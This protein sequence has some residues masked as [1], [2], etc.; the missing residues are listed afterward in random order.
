MKPVVF[1]ANRG[2]IA[3]RIARSL[4]SLGYGSA[5]VFAPDDAMAP[6]RWLLTSCA[7][8]AAPAGYTD[9]AAL[10]AHARRAGATFVHP[11]YGFLS[12]DAGFAEAVADA[13]LTWVGP[14]PAAMRALGDKGAARVR[15]SALGLPIVEGVS[16]LRDD[17]AIGRAAAALGYPLLLKAP[18]AGGGR[19]LVRIDSAAGLPAATARARRVAGA[20]TPLV[21]ER[22]L[23][24]VRHVEVQVV[25]DGQRAMA[26]GTR[27]CST[28]RRL[29]KVIEEAPATA[30]STQAA[31]SMGAQ[32]E[33]LFVD[34]GYAGVGTAEF[35]LDADGHWTFLEVNPR[36][37]V[38]HTVTEE[39]FGIDLVAWQL[40][41]AAGEPL[42]AQAPLA[43]G[44]SIEARLTAEDPAADYTPQTGTVLLAHWPQGPGIRVDA[45][46]AEGSVV[47][48]A[49]DALL[50]KIVAT[51][52]TR[53]QA[54]ARLL[55]ALEEVQ[56]LGVGHNVAHLCAL[57]R[58]DAFVADRLHTAWLS[59]VD[60]GAPA[61]PAPLAAYIAGR[62]AAPAGI[63]WAARGR[64]PRASRPRHASAFAVLDGFGRPCSA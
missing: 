42:P 9:G 21:L 3:A 18:N 36:L 16:D 50:A 26:L 8:L 58:N 10:L 49:Y 55:Q 37:Q 5:G 52:P 41:I 6:H 28:Q 1:V 56:L 4:R 35:L 15:A 62:D 29:Q 51:A 64:E 17:A 22:W 43:R 23:R 57:L 11:G 33:R 13:K 63:T 59:D 60:S 53:A 38:E 27:D 19:G 14:S 46:V 54:R 45:G 40:A 20:D 39:I 32:A 34:A 31:A 7:P 2:E 30:L 47:S 48:G 44:H 24:V 25:A 61:P 12:Q